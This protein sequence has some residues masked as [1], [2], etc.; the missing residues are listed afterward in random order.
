[1]KRLI[2][3]IIA[4]VALAVPVTASAHSGT[5]TC[6]TTGV[7]FAYHSD[8]PVTTTVT[9]HVGSITKTVTVVAHTAST[10]TI[11]G[12]TTPPGGSI[13]ASATW[14]GGGTIPPTTLVCPGPPPAPPVTP[15]PPPTCKAGDVSE[16]IVNGVLVCD[17]TI[18]IVTP[19]APPP[20]P[21]FVV[22]P[23][24]T[25]N[26]G[27]QSGILTCLKTQIKIK[28][29]TKVITKIKWVVWCPLP[30]KPTPGVTG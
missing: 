13:V 19:P 23:K 16:G 24:G 3:G 29:K 7:V 8:F 20:P 22:C 2:A 25:K 21:P 9:E 10:D 1:M 12:I 28:V 18:T 4:V 30:P 15:T 14:V 27:I 6:N 26:L 17:H 5:V 11:P